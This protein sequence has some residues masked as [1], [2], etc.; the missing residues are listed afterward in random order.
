MNPLSNSN[1]RFSEREG[2][3]EN[4]GNN[5]NN[6]EDFRHNDTS[7]FALKKDQYDCNMKNLK[8]TFQIFECLKSKNT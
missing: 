1:L 5:N 8:N 4:K 3:K 2:P 6:V 7:K